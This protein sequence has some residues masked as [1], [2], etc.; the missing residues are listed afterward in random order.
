[1]SLV[2]T[3]P[4]PE[5]RAKNL[6]QRY[7][8]QPYPSAWFEMLVAEI[9]AAEDA[10]RA[11]RLVSADSSRPIHVHHA[12]GASWVRLDD[13]DHHLRA[14]EDAALE[15]AAKIAEDAWKDDIDSHEGCIVSMK[16]DIAKTIRSFKSGGK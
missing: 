6:V 13:A 14:K 2:V 10:V 15:R 3:T 12:N 9:R 11:E 7:Q 1:M 5:E 16:N 8:S 4:T